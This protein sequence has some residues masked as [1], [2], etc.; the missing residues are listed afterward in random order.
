MASQ[1]MKNGEDTMTAE[2]LKVYDRQIRLWGLAG[3][4]K[5]VFI[6]SHFNFVMCVMVCFKIRLRSLKVLL[7]GM[8]GLGAEVAKNLILSGIHS[9]VLKDHTDVSILDRCSQ[10]LI[11]H[12]SQERNVSVAFTY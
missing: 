8:Q 12:N 3:Q 6:M 4:N 2:E 5:Y 11:P 1:V 10:F 7:V 9:I